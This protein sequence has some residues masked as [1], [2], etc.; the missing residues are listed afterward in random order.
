[1]FYFVCKSKIY[2]QKV[3]APRIVLRHAIFPKVQKFWENFAD[4]GDTW[5]RR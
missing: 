3:W 1:M 4:S 5:L 2:D